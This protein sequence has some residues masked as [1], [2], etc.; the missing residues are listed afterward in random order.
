MSES[1]S[2]CRYSDLLLFYL[3]GVRGCRA[4]CNYENP[5]PSH[6]KFWRRV[7]FLFD[8]R[9]RGSLEG[10]F[11]LCKLVTLCIPTRGT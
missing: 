6:L 10:H 5:Y 11:K 3:P 9:P 2:K 1:S 7:W 8:K 4:D